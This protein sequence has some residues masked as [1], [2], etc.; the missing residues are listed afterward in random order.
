MDMSNITVT[1]DV[2][3]ANTEAVAAVPGNGYRFVCCAGLTVLVGVLAY[4]YA[5]KPV[6]AKIRTRK[7]RHVIH[8]KADSAGESGVAE[9]SK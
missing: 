1:E 2:M 4:R 6:M 9:E 7:E 8:V 3:E 5:V